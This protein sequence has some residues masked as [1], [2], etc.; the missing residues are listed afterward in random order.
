MSL[1]DWH[2]MFPGATPCYTTAYTLC[3]VVSNS[4]FTTDNICKL[5]QR[6]NE[7]QVHLLEA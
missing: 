7:N 6:P 4:H 3:T 2:Q 1:S 5:E